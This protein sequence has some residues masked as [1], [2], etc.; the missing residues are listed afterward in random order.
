MSPIEPTTLS[1]AIATAIFGGL[2]GYFFAQASSLGLFGPPTKKGKRKAPKRSWPNSY[3]VTVHPDSSDEELMAHLN[4]G[5]AGADSGRGSEE[6]EETD[7]EDGDDDEEAQDGLRA[8]DG[9]SEEHKL[10]LVVRTDLGMGKGAAPLP[11]NHPVDSS[12]PKLRDG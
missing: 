1:I 11:P 5:K 9:S 7:G 3:D 4:G 10:V 6:S 12:E 2:G 8:F